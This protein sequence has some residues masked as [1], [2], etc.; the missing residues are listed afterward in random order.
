M[1]LADPGDPDFPNLQ[2]SH[3]SCA[4]SQHVSGSAE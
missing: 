4:E 3:F 2:P 1:S